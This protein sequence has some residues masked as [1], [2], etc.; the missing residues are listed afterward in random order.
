MNGL[1]ALFLLWCAALACTAPGGTNSFCAGV[2]PDRV[3][4]VGVCMPASVLDRAKFDAG[5]AALKDAGYR[6][7]LAPRLKFD[8]LASPQDRAAD[9]ADLWTDPEVDL[10]L[11][12]R[13]GSRVEHI[14]PYIDWNR[15]RTRPDQTFLG[16]S[17][18]TVLHNA[19][20]AKG[21][22]HPVSGPTMSA[23][24]RASRE[25]KDWLRR[26]LGGKP[27]PPVQLRV[28]KPGACAGLPCGGHAHRYLIAHRL[29]LAGSAQGKVV[30]LESEASIGLT[31]LGGTLDYLATSGALDGC[32]G[33]VFGDLTPGLDEGVRRPGESEADALARARAEV[34]RMVR[35]FADRVPCPVYE[36]FDYG[37]GAT[38]LA[39][40]HLRRVSVDAAGVMRWE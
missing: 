29:G 32:A 37:H 8:G 21:V 27:Q 39:V 28:V 40:D 33:V 24:P 34:A 22:G 12:A 15:L 6:V 10:V 26:A 7:K 31:L 11:C 3:K 5:V 17:D 18:I 4:T 1:R 9:L 30:F 14:V 25:T 36:G 2:F 23:F 13:G 35:R 16:F 38:N 20:L 19:F